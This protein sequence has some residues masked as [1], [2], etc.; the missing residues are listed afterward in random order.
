M[1]EKEILS[2]FLGATLNL[3]T[4][5]IAELLYKKSDE[6]TLTDEIQ[7][8]VLDAL[9]NLDKERVSKLKPDTK[10]F[11]DNGYKK[12]QA[13]VSANWEKL[14]REKT[15][16]DADLTGEELLIAAIEKVGKPSKMDEDKLKSHPLYL[17]LEKKALEDVKAARS[18]GLQALEAYKKEMQTAGRRQTAQAKA[19]E[20]LLG[21]KPVLEDDPR[22]ADRRIGYFLKEFEGLDYELLEDGSLVP[23][24]EGKRLE[25]EHAHPVDFETLV[26]SIASESFKFQ[27]QDP[28]GNGG[29]K[30]EPGGGT[31]GSKPGETPKDEADLW[32]RYAEAKTPEERNAVMDAWEKANGPIPVI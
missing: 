29:N 30:N 22:I 17:A 20:I 12:A 9:K 24:K 23:I 27:A 7:D 14:I 28:K 25:N 11:F 26:K 32:K 16:I 18:E 2:A 1:N 31:G 3:P 13:E 6:G 21:M 15:G 10:Q 8:G 5:K 4:D 19:K